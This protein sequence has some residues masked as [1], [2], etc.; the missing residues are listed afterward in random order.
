[1]WFRLDGPGWRDSSLLDGAQRPRPAYQAF[2]FLATV[3][4]GATYEGA[5]STGA[6]EGYRFRK[7][8]ILYSICWTNDGS[9]VQ[10]QLPPGTAT[11][12]DKVGTAR[13]PGGS[14]VAVN[15]EPLIAES[16][17]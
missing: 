13:A 2:A 1:V 15:A 12:Y 6:L 17:P 5:F 8:A 11:L 16:V 3:L 14:T 4:K 7:G 9:E 10:V